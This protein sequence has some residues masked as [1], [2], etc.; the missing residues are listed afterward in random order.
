[1]RRKV[2]LSKTLLT[3]LYIKREMS[4]RTVAAH[5]GLNSATSVNR[6]L[7]QFGVPRRKSGAKTKARV[8][9]HNSRKTGYEEICGSYWYAVKSNA[10]KRGLEFAITLEYA[11]N[12]FLQQERKCALSGRHLVHAAKTQR[13]SHQKEQTASL[14]RIDSGKGYFPGNVQWIHKDLQRMK[15]AF[16]DDYFIRTCGEVV[17]HRRKESKE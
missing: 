5:L 9:F 7:R 8:V 13:D 3:E 10:R 12:I 14:D 4:A 1:M 15:W 16:S 6:A 2:Q 11:W 17:Q